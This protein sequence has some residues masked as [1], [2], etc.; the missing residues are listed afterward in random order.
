MKKRFFAVIACLLL[1]FV[2]SCPAFADDD[3][4]AS[5]KLTPVS[6]YFTIKASDVQN[7]SFDIENTGTKPFSF[8]VY[9]APYNIAGENYDPDF[10]SDTT[11]NQ[12]AR[13]ITF[14]DQNGDYVEEAIYSVQPGS[15][16][17][18]DYRITVPENIPSGSQQCVIFSETINN[19]VLTGTSI[20]TV[21]RVAH[22]VL[23]HGIGDTTNFG[24]VIDFHTTG[25]FTTSEVFASA[26]VKNSGN[27]DILSAYTF[28]IETI[29]G[30]KVYEK[31][32]TFTMFPETERKFSSTWENSPLFGIFK[33]HYLAN[34]GGNVR[35]TTHIVIILPV[36]MMIVFILLLTFMVIWIIILIRKRKERRAR[37]VI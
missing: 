8:K 19:D 21:S 3:S 4:T 30:N 32:E 18:V 29:F 27:I 15:K 1:G 6:N 2:I 12:I 17:T 9:T 25:L 13:W 7:Y 28:E 37:L 5:I 16:T 24:E 26:K 34:A 10:D 20:R 22:V 23:G 36:V 14:K 31:A 35:E 11:Y 33:I